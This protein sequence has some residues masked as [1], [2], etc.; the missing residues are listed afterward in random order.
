M[1]A[2][3]EVGRVELPPLRG[4]VEPGHEP[5]G[6]L[7]VRDVQHNLYEGEAVLDQIVLKAVDLL[8]PTPP[9]RIGRQPPYPNGQDVLVMRPVEDADVTGRR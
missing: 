4:V 7:L 9:H 8:V 3:I 2:V 1:I 5:V 6:L